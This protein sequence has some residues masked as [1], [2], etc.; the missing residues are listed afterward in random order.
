MWQ[1]DEIWVEMVS[2]EEAIQQL[3]AA[4][5][6]HEASKL[7]EWRNVLGNNQG[8]DGWISREYPHV[9]AVLWPDR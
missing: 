5:L 9:V 2:K 3:R 1:Q 7:D 4:G 6:D 8:W